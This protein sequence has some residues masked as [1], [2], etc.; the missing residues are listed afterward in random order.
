[1]VAGSGG[2]CGWPGN[3]MI[4]SVL[5]APERVP[6]LDSKS[7]WTSRTGIP[8]W[9]TQTARVSTGTR[10][11]SPHTTASPH[12]I[13]SCLWWSGDDHAVEARRRGSRLTTKSLVG[14]FVIHPSSRPP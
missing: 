9:K 7:D 2:G 12:T 11:G 6:P 10:I 14:P 8:T 5:P 13:D 4:P 1:M 3:S